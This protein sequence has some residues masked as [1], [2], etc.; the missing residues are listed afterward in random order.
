MNQSESSCLAFIERVQSQI[1]NVPSFH[2]VNSCLD[3]LRRATTRAEITAMLQTLPATIVDVYDR[4][5]LSIPKAYVAQARRVFQWIAFS[6]R[7]LFLDEVAEAAIISAGSPLDL[8]NRF[9]DPLD[10]IDICSSLVMISSDREGETRR[11]RISFT[12][13]SVK[14]YL[15]SN[16]IQSSSA[17]AYS[18]KEID[19]QNLITE[20]AVTYQLTSMRLMSTQSDRP[21]PFPL[22]DYAKQYWYRH[23]M[24]AGDGGRGSRLI[25]ESVIELFDMRRKESILKGTGSLDSAT[26]E[27][28]ELT[29]DNSSGFPPALYYAS[30]LGMNAV[31]QK[32]LNRGDEVDLIG[33]FCGTALQ[34]AAY[35][36]H[37]QVIMRLLEHD[38]DV[39]AVSGY[40]G[41]ALQSS[42][43]RGNTLS[44]Q[45]L[46][47][48]GADVNSA[49]GYYG[50]ALQASA[51]EGHLP[52]VQLLMEFGADVNATGGA[53]QSAL[54]ASASGGHK[55]VTE[56][57]LENGAKINT[58]VPGEIPTAIYGA[59][60]FGHSEV[61]A[62]LLDKG[63]D[64]NVEGGE[65][66]NALKAAAKAGSSEIVEQLLRSGAKLT[67]KDPSG[68]D[69]GIAALHLA[70]ESGHQDVIT[71]LLRRGI[72]AESMSQEGITP[73]VKAASNGR[74]EVVRLLLENAA[75]P[76]AKDK[77]G[78]TA[79]MKAVEAGH[80][81]VMSLL[82]AYGAEVE[83]VNEW[84]QT[85]LMR[86]AEAGQRALVRMLLDF[87]ASP[88]S[89][90]HAGETVLM[91]AVQSD[92][93]EVVPPLLQ[94]GAEVEAYNQSGQSALDIAKCKGKQN[95]VKLLEAH[96]AA[97]KEDHDF[98]AQVT[99]RKDS[100]IT[101]L[102]VI[103][104]WEQSTKQ[105]LD[106]L[107]S[108]SIQTFLTVLR[109][110]RQD[111]PQLI[112][113]IDSTLKGRRRERSRR[114]I[115]PV[116]II[117]V[118]RP[119]KPR[120]RGAIYSADGFD[121][122]SVERRRTPVIHYRDD[123][124]DPTINIVREARRHEEGRS[125]RRLADERRMLEMELEEARMRRE[126]DERR[127]RRLETEEA[128][129]RRDFD[130][131]RSD[132]FR[133]RTAPEPERV[134]LED[135]RRGNHWL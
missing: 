30:L 52:E 5:L 134:M 83:S 56:I 22:L 68:E 86:A 14:E 8:R 51:S 105:Q 95:V 59:S 82:F 131:R 6:E 98:E 100:P 58:L 124:L 18:L 128:R 106:G 62:L 47:D 96:C 123:L 94:A 19:A 117:E 135:Q 74:K 116:Q 16:H 89:T 54:I 91:Y 7:E 3:L 12:H 70:V 119:R 81:E 66:G 80:E 64:A 109:Q 120:R 72:N 103:S 60:F 37:V 39:N 53:Y 31:V 125:I 118:D 76:M 122:Y 33:G 108:K 92:N 32:L 129:E 130:R 126:R 69:T 110:S 2:W 15:L 43:F 26:P 97:K 101:D 132:G 13:S 99:L 21:D 17:A 40:F 11:N 114:E 4:M 71:L 28:P 77:S 49:C 104:Q 113:L 93:E 63:A 112:N 127:M 50:N 88:R 23:Y 1:T 111:V 133:R 57:L 29:Y 107:D 67:L 90:D 10:I 75:N 55:F 78:A 102:K 121:D 79:M 84:G 87:G 20:A 45:V 46:L 38:A 73:L 65:Y 9:P 42:S 24:Q 35:N 34:A 25:S 61:V 48:S 115:S 27:G 41:D 44:V 36:N 85:L